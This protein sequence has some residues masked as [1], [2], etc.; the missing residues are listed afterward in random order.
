MDISNAFKPKLQILV[1]Q[2]KEDEKI[3]KPLLDSIAV[4]QRVDLTRDISVIIVNDGSDTILDKVFLSQYPYRIEYVM[5]DHNGVSAARNIALDLATADYIMW[6]DADDMFYISHALWLIL[7]DIQLGTFDMMNSIFLEEVYTKDGNLKDLI[8]HEHDRTFVHGKVYRRRYLIDNDIRWNTKLHIH[9]DVYF[10][11]LAML[12][13][14]NVKY[15]ETFFYL[16]C[17]RKDSICRTDP[18]Y[19]MKTFPNLID[20]NDEL[21][22]EL[23]RRGEEANAAYIMLFVSFDTYY[24]LQLPL[25]HMKENSEYRNA[26]ENRYAKL[27]KK[28]KDVLAKAPVDQRVKTSTG[29]RERM[30]KSGM[31]MEL[32]SFPTWIDHIKEL[33]AEGE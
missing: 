18:K 19:I 2:Y 4:Q 25:W 5:S 33:I 22:T 28:Y 17:Y 8:K 14:K 15:Q 6:C 23:L 26:T 9:E 13:T 20:T 10:T 11:T 31:V 3:I 1:P 21:I 24:S 12:L 27:Y 32:I 7:R 29:I 16:W 30:L